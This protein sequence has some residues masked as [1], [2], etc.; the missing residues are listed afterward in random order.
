MEK[1]LAGR[2]FAGDDNIIAAIKG[3]LESQARVFLHWDK[4]ALALLEQMFSPREGLC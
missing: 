2:H 3:F 4:T 1:A